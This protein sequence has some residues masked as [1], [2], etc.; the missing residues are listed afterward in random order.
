[1]SE[2]K[3]RLLKEL[4]DP[5][6]RGYYAEQH[7]NSTLATQ[8]R[9]VREQ[10]GYTQAKLAERAGMHQAAVS[11]IENVNY[12]RWNIGTLKKIAESL[13]CWL[14][15]RLESWGKL[16]TSVEEYSPENL[17][18]ERFEED[19]IFIGSRVTSGVPESVRWVQQKLFPALGATGGLYTT[20]TMEQ[21]LPAWLQGR[22][23]P[24]VG[25]RDQ[26]Y[27]WIV[28]AIEAEGP[29][30]H[31]RKLLKG[32]LARFL[33][34]AM[35]IA[36]TLDRGDDYLAGLFSLVAEFH[37]PALFWE[38]I[39]R[40][41]RT[42]LPR[43][44]PVAKASF[45]NALI[46]NQKNFE[47]KE[48]WLKIIEQGE[49][50]LLPMNE[51]DGFEGVMWI[52]ARPNVRAIAEGLKAMQFANWNRPEREIDLVLVMKD[53]KRTFEGFAQLDQLLWREGWDVG[54]DIQVARA[55]EQVF[56]PTDDDRVRIVA[57][58]SGKPQRMITS[59][60][61]KTTRIEANN[62]P[63]GEDPT[64]ANNLAYLKNQ[65]TAAA[66]G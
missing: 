34:E 37:D 50:E 15:I 30:S 24:P 54:W 45:V 32:W 42:E 46:R 35:E 52:P 13:G 36:G 23:L 14:D 8:I 20:T 25:D 61:L 22:D 64:L 40:L 17:R 66:S 59:E 65:L 39:G 60:L 31:P 29:D 62:K 26:P 19:P 57:E 27:T 5:E 63:P 6:Y 7:L 9:T 33:S 18:R 3:E 1:M 48:L 41:F 12:A 16:V 49:H 44:S 10:R 28:R 53:V 55:W 2:R 11:R 4:A 38:P 58:W 51:F 43:M 47:L 21:L 56:V